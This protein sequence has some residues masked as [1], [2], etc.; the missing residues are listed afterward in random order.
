MDAGHELLLVE[1]DST[2]LELLALLLAGDGW[3][4]ETAESGEA[5]LA[6]LRAAISAPAVILCDQRLP[7]LCGSPLALAIKTLLR[8]RFDSADT[9]LLAMSAT[10]GPEPPQGYAG[11]LQKP[12]AAAAVRQSLL[13]PQQH[14]PATLL[15]PSQ[16]PAVPSS[17]FP[18]YSSWPIVDDT[19]IAQLRKS[20]PDRRLQELFDFAIADAGDRLR[21]LSSFSHE[22]SHELFVREA[23]ALKGS[24]GVIGAKQL[25]HLAQEA[26]SLP[27]EPASF[28]SISQNKVDGMHAA[29]EQLRLMLV[30]LFSL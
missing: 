25:W 23:H 26:E 6:W 5:A 24:F 11:L 17:A 7:G 18:A 19:T 3:R 16:P 20:M 9:A 14:R 22:G 29:M 12:F 15:A 28:A 2:T 21:K 10:T 30:S 4:V 1:D 8:D 27:P 13:T